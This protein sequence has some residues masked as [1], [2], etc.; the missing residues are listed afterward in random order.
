MVIDN[1]VPVLKFKYIYVHKLQSLVETEIFLASSCAVGGVI[2]FVILSEQIPLAP[3][4][5]QS[6]S[7]LLANDHYH[8]ST[9]TLLELWLQRR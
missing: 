1:A 6:K 9:C 3:A 5:K 7:I 2:E 4:K 8:R